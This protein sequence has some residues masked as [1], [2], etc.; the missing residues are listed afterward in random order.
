[1]FTGYPFIGIKSFYKYERRK[2]AF[3]LATG[4]S[5]G[6]VL[7]ELLRIFKALSECLEKSGILAVY[8]M[9]I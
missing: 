5:L 1:M 3:S 9:S 8:L 6:Q 4:C 2:K 7:Q